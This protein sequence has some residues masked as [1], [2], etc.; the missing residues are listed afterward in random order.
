MCFLTFMYSFNTVIIALQTCGMKIDIDG[1]DIRNRYIK[2]W[3]ESPVAKN[4]NVHWSFTSAGMLDRKFVS[5]FDM[6]GRT[7]SRR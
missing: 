2:E 1:T 4:L 7:K 6:S 3:N 5:H